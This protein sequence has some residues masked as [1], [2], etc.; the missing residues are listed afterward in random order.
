MQAQQQREKKRIESVM[1]GQ[2][3]TDKVAALLGDYSDADLRRIVSMISSDMCTYAARLDAEKQ[4]HRKEQQVQ[5][6]LGIVPEMP[7][8]V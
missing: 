5:P 4:A 1:I 3:L 6:K 8:Q 2:L 7:E